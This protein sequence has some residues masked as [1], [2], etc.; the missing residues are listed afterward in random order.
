MP[1]GARVQRAL[2]RYFNFYRPEPD[3][4]HISEF[5]LTYSGQPLKTRRCQ[6]L[7]KRCGHKA[8]IRGIRLSPHTL[9]HTAALMWIRNGGDVFSLQRILGHSTLDIVRIYVNLAQSD[10][11]AAHRIYSPADNLDLKEPTAR[12]FKHGTDRLFA[13]SPLERR[14]GNGRRR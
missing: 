7:I 2:L 3:S 8:G 1:F 5:F 14:K 10:I 9:R 12:R 13:H 11:E 4:P 6:E